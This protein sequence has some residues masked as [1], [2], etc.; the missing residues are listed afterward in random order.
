MT[1]AVGQWAVTLGL[2]MLAAM[3][4]PPVFLPTRDVRVAYRV[5]ATVPH[6]REVVVSYDAD[7]RRARI[8]AAGEPA[9][10]LVDRGKGDVTLVIDLL[11]GTMS[12]PFD[13]ERGWRFVLGRQAAFTELGRDRVAGMPCRV[14]TV[15]T[16]QGDA[17]A[18]LTADGVLLRAAF[19]GS[20]RGTGS[21]EATSVA[22]AHQPRALFEVPPGFRPLP[23]L[24]LAVLGLN[25][26]PA[27]ASSGPAR[28]DYRQSDQRGSR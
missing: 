18:C 9:Y 21:I 25:F 11:R 24:P 10:A 12:L 27:S 5:V 4:P 20:R 26:S 3:T 13:V 14:W 28:T 2:L 6:P 17:T 15:H 23:A 8:D 19:T 1:R 7:L 22:Y 16:R